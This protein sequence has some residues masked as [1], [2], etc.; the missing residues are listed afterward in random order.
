MKFTAVQMLNIIQIKIESNL[1][2]V[3]GN[4]VAELVLQLLSNFVLQTAAKKAVYFE[5]KNST[6]LGYDLDQL[7]Y[8]KLY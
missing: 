8:K 1:A 2:N 7:P 4:R 5:E 6:P 3:C